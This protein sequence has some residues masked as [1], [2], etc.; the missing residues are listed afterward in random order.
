MQSDYEGYEL[1]GSART[2]DSRLFLSSNFQTNHDNT[3][4]QKTSTFYLTRHQTNAT[5]QT[6]AGWPSL[7]VGFGDQRQ[8][9]DSPTL[10]IRN[11][12]RSWLGGFNHSLSFFSYGY[13]YSLSQYRDFSPA[14]LSHDFDNTSHTG[15]LSLSYEGFSLSGS[16][17]QSVNKDFVTGNRTENISFSGRLAGKLRPNIDAEIS[18]SQNKGTDHQSTVQNDQQTTLAKV[19]WHVTSSTFWRAQYERIAFTNQITPTQ[20]YDESRTTLAYGFDF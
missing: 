5:I 18:R 7:L 14:P 15:N 10:P 9:V 6:L 17:G 12:T 19:E 3:E 2:R 4:G 1:Q 16:V 20:S 8:R 13:V 11:R